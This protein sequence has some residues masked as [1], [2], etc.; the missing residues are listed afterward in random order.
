[1]AQKTGRSHADRLTHHCTAGC[2]KAIQNLLFVF[3]SLTL[4]SNPWVGKHVTVEFQSQALTAKGGV[5]AGD[6]HPT[7]FHL[8]LNLGSYNPAV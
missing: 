7:T 1:M 3:G 4:F 6:P 2:H 8:R 5:G